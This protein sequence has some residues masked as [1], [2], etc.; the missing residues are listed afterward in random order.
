[1]PEFEQSNSTNC[2][3][4]QLFLDHSAGRRGVGLF[5]STGGGGIRGSFVRISHVSPSTVRGFSLFI[6]VFVRSKESEREIE[7]KF[8]SGPKT[9]GYFLGNVT[10]KSAGYQ[11]TLLH[12][13]THEL[14]VQCT[15]KVFL[16]AEGQK[17]ALS[18]SNSLKL[19][20]LGNYPITS[21]SAAFQ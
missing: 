14:S 13:P 11:H 9:M 4:R 7:S 1:M 18:K 5:S 16:E 2:L 20:L 6:C 21:A 17:C 19:L 10:V 15:N 8:C 3:R 12:N